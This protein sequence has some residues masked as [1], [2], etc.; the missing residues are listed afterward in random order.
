MKWIPAYLLK[1]DVDATGITQLDI[2]AGET[3]WHKVGQTDKRNKTGTVWSDERKRSQ[4][5]N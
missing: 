2:T 4:S 5:E 3:F 1:K